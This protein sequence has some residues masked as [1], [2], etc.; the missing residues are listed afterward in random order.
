MDP[1][2]FPQIAEWEPEDPR[3]VLC[4]YVESNTNWE[5]VPMTDFLSAAELVVEHPRAIEQVQNATL[6]NLLADYKKV[7][8]L[9]PDDAI[10]QQCARVLFWEG[11]V[12]KLGVRGDLGKEMPEKDLA[13]ERRRDQVKAVFKIF[14]YVKKIASSRMGRGALALQRLYEQVEKAD[15]EAAE[16]EALDKAAKEAA[17]KETL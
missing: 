8:D 15:R 9:A 4:S 14:A 17:E 12:Y 10:I 1:V 6:R 11:S 2:N 13:S 16:K 3:L 5:K 7:L